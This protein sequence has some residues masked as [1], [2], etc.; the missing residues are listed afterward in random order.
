ML[1]PTRSISTR[2]IT[3]PPVFLQ[4]HLTT[5]L[6]RNINN[7]Q[8]RITSIMER[9]NEL[10]SIVVPQKSFSSLP[11]RNVQVFDGSLLQYHAFM[12]PFEQVSETKT[13][14]VADG[15][16]FLRKSILTWLLQCHE[17]GA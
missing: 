13:I 6:A 12:H 3:T 4:S 9:Q 5:D 11:R 2:S 15:L 7:E 1:I 16:H 10:T 8:S 14:D 17:G